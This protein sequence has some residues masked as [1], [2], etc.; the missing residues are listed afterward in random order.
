ML[1]LWKELVA[2]L[3]SPVDD[4]SPAGNQ[5]NT[6]REVI[7]LQAIFVTLT[8]A[9]LAYI[10]KEPAFRARVAATF[11]LLALVPIMGLC[12]IIR[13]RTRTAAGEVFTYTRPVRVYA[14]QA[15]AVALL[16]LLGL[17]YSY[18]Q[19]LLPGQ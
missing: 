5:A 8:I 17:S 7:A 13:G 12:H 19:G 9:L 11:V 18:W 15:L 3:R 4:A 6:Y 16:I 10:Q 1:E 14:R 2:V